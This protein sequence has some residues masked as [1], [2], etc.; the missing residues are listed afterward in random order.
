MPENNAS[1]D[2][3][4][5]PVDKQT[6]GSF[7][8]ISSFCARHKETIAAIGVIGTLMI[9]LER[10]SAGQIVP[11]RDGISSLDSKI[12]ELRNDTHDEFIVV[13]EDLRDVR[14]DVS[15]VKDDVA[16][17]R[18]EVRELSVRLENAKDSD[19][20]LAMMSSEQDR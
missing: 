18:V 6:Q 1:I 14:A 15:V 13:R 5:K 8:L 10:C 12:E 2:M 17:M 4:V 9:A 19:P 16:D 11:L 3:A 7:Q 20:Q